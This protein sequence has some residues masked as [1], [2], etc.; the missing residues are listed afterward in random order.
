MST[1]KSLTI[2]AIAVVGL[3]VSSSNASARPIRFAARAAVRT[4]FVAS[5]AAVRATPPYRPYYRPY[6]RYYGGYARP[7]YNAA[8]PYY[9]PRYYY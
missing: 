5:R 1:M 7:Y 4:P 8:R 2:A 6:G 3:I 9:V